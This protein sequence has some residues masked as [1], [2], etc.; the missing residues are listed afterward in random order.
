MV[1]VMSF[2][3]G[4]HYWVVCRSEIEQQKKRIVIEFDQ[5]AEEVPNDMYS[6]IL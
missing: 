3:S 4:R 5:N 6:D 2:K 1:H